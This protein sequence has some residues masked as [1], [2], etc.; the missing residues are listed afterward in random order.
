MISTESAQIVLAVLGIL[1]IVGGVM[2]ARKGS[3]ASLRAGAMSG[4]A[5]F[6]SLVLATS[7]PALGLWTGTVVAL[8]LSVVFGLR[9]RATGK[10]MP[11]GMLLL[12]C[13]VGAAFLLAAALAV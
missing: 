8:A 7:N 12:L 10:F 3:R 6:L 2:G 9:L 1:M 5:F 13:L 4:L 11:A